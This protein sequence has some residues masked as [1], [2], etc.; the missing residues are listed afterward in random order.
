M[1]TVKT[2]YGDILDHIHKCFGEDFSQDVKRKKEKEQTYEL[3][4]YKHRR[5]SVCECVIERNRGRKR[6]HC[7]SKAEMKAWRSTNTKESDGR[8]IKKWGRT[9]IQLQFRAEC[10]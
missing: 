8:E 9:G 6:E 10:F 3:L 5:Q 1:T 4:E 2:K 7:I